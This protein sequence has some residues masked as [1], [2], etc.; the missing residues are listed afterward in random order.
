MDR[1]EQGQICNG[2]VMYVKNFKLCF[3]GLMRYDNVLV[4]LD[5]YICI[6]DG[7]PV[8]A[9]IAASNCHLTTT[10]NAKVCIM[11]VNYPFYTCFCECS[12]LRF[13]NIMILMIVAWKA[14]TD[15]FAEGWR[16]YC[17]MFEVISRW[18]GYPETYKFKYPMLMWRLRNWVFRL[19]CFS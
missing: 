13:V 19:L 15:V 5:L 10:I 16:F 14:F 2:F 3:V 8:I 9:T 18:C 7:T 1:S 4:L 6:L 12:I 17:T 11:Y